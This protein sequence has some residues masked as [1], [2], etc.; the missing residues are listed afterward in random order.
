MSDAA[1]KCPPRKG[2]VKAWDGFC[3]AM[4]LWQGRAEKRDGE[5]GLVYFVKAL[6]AHAAG[7]TDRFEHRLAESAECITVANRHAALRRLFEDAREEG[8][9]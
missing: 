2:D 4:A 7:D 9:A 1:P 8:A 5:L 3:V 6:R